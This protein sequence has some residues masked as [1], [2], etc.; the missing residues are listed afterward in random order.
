MTTSSP[1]L[2]PSRIWALTSSLMPIFT[3]RGCILPWAITNTQ[4]VP[5]GARGGQPGKRMPLLECTQVRPTT[6][7][8]GPM[9]ASN[10]SISD[11]VVAV[12]ASVVHP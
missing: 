1:S 12:A 5:A 8:F 2:R 3:V 9:P 4:S 7:V 11:S 6:R 10:A